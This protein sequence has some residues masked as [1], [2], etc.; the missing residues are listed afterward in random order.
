MACCAWSISGCPPGTDVFETGHI[1]V[2]FVDRGQL[3]IGQ[4]PHSFKQRPI[5]IRVLTISN[6]PNHLLQEQ[7]FFSSLIISSLFMF[8]QEHACYRFYTLNHY[9]DLSGNV[10]N[11]RSSLDL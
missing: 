10:K 7:H 8:Q 6:T 3:D 2:F 1:I 11:N 5:R 9:K 4:N